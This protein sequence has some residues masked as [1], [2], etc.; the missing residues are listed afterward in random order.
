V[1][2]IEVS[3]FK[4]K[5]PTL[6]KLYSDLSTGLVDRIILVSGQISVQAATESGY[7]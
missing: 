7:D 6:T 3:G 5:I 2:I 4:G 1:Q